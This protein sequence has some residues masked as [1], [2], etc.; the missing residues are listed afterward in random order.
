[1]NPRSNRLQ[2]NPNYSPK[3]SE[4]ESSDQSYRSLIH[5]DQIE[6]TIQLIEGMKFTVSEWGRNKMY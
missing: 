6:N 1:M 5:E 2:I 4:S 3:S